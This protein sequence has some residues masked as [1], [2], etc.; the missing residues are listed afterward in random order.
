MAM[1]LLQDW[2]RGLDVDAHRAL[3]VTGIPEGLEQEHIEAALQPSLLPLG[4]FR[5][6]HMKAL[7]NEKAQ[8]TLAEF[9]EDVNHAAIPKEIPGQDGVWRVLWKDCA[10]DTRVLRQMRR[11]LLDDGP[12]VG[13]THTSR[14]GDP[15]PGVSTVIEKAGPPPGAIRIVARR[16]GGHRN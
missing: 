2:C 15:G 13:G 3:L 5:L 12:L 6:R 10:Q 14:F 1:S 16:G 7:T 4:T 9:V 11:L 8:A